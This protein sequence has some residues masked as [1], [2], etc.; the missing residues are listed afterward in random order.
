MRQRRRM[1]R[2]KAQCAKT[3]RKTGCPSLA[4]EGEDTGSV[5]RENGTESAGAGGE[6]DE[7]FISRET[8]VLCL[9]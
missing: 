3:D 5:C 6:K 8:A 4:P 9:T 1:R 7:R 2:R